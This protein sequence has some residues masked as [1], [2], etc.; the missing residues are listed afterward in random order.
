MKRVFLLLVAV[1]LHVMAFVLIYEWGRE[2]AESLGRHPRR[3]IG[4]GTLVHFAFYSFIVISLTLS[5]A[6]FFRL[7]LSYLVVGW[8][9]GLGWLCWILVPAMSA[10]PYR[11]SFILALAVLLLSSVQLV[12]VFLRPEKIVDQ[13][14]TPNL[15]AE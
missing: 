15:T 2:Y 1:A 7:R 11:A 6:T 4:L 5:F 3:S 12:S 13:K 9:I 8:I 14:S 10:Y